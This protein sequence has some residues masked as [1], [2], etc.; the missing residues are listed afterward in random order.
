MK[1]DKIKNKELILTLEF[2]EKTR[3]GDYSKIE[4]SSLKFIRLKEL[5]E[6]DI[7]EEIYYYSVS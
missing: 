3:N 5:A 2:L 1:E 6:A 4:A 7:Q